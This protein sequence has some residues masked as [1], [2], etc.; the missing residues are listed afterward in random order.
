MSEQKEQPDNPDR[1]KAKRTNT[2]L[3]IAVGV[4]G[5]GA[6]GAFYVL[7]FLMMFLKPGLIFSIM[8]VPSI[9]TSV[10]SDGSRTYFLFQKIDMSDL[11]PREKREPKTKH[12]VAVLEGTA[13]GESREVLPYASALGGNNRLVLLNEGSYR[14]Y[15]G[16][17]W[18]EVKT[19]GIG[20]EP[21]GALTPLGMYVL[22]S[23][24]DGARLNR[25]TDGAVT[26]IPLPKAF[27]D[28]K[29]SDHC[30]CTQLVWYQGHLCLFWTEDGS[31]A[32]T[33]WNGRVWAPVAAS[34]FSG[35]YQV[36]ADGQR[37][38]FFHRQGETP[39]RTL[40]YS[41][42]SN[43]AWSGPVRLPLPGGFTV[44]DAFIGQGRPM[45]FAQQITS[46]TLYTIE[47]GTLAN[48][49]RLKGPFHPASM[50]GRLALV[51]ACANLSMFLAIFG[52]SAV[53]NRF[54][55]R[56]WTQD[57][58]RYE[59]AS[60]FRR[61]IAYF[62]DNILL[63]L[64]FAVAIAFLF[65]SGDVSRNPLGFVV[66][67]M[68]AVVFFFLGG[69]LYHSLLE[70]LIGQTLGKKL[71]GIRVL[72]ADFTPCGLG[73]GFLRNL[74]RIL[75]AFFYYLVAAVS[76]AGTFKWQR[77]GDLLAE[78]VVVRKKRTEGDAES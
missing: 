40:S 36:V 18:T 13:L 29:K 49:I 33:A 3:A 42:F 62:I 1:E 50:I 22:S 14:T 21:R 66:M 65:R 11:S 2:K 67:M 32:W 73:A 41:V 45:L 52:F 20:K 4:L 30:S 43:N 60:L 59:F 53:I 61:F 28:A 38:Y 6:F 48:P 7:F 35:G 34:P 27:P 54:K 75:D 12:F 72:K 78:T 37:L 17:R 71:C 23:F 24:E 69:F 5:M 8:P 9:T 58:T 26:S 19:D 47:N 15:D 74:L 64:P 68:F 46:Q 63:L 56:F 44:W 10:L 51:A 76:L 57:G 25:I 77:V 70:G 55:D 39:N 31:L 16:V